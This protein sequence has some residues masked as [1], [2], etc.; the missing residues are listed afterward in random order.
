[1]SFNS[2][3]Y[4]YKRNETMLSGKHFRRKTMVTAY[5]SDVVEEEGGQE[6]G[7]TVDPDLIYFWDFSAA[8]YTEEKIT[9]DP[10]FQLTESDGTACRSQI[11][12][13]YGEI[14]VPAYTQANKY[15]SARNNNQPFPLTTF[16][17]FKLEPEITFLYEYNVSG[18]FNLFQN[19][20]KKSTML[21]IQPEMLYRFGTVASSSDPDDPLQPSGISSPINVST[22]LQTLRSANTGYPN[23][24]NFSISMF[25]PG[26]TNFYHSDFDHDTLTTQGVFQ[27]CVNG[28]GHKLAFG[29]RTD[30]TYRYFFVY[31]NK[32]YFEKSVGSSVGN[33]TNWNRHLPLIN[34]R[35]TTGDAV[36]NLK[37]IKIYK[38]FLQPDEIDNKTDRFPFL[39]HFVCDQ[40][41]TYL[42]WQSTSS[43]FDKVVGDNHVQYIQFNDDGAI[44]SYI[45][46][47]P[48]DMTSPVIWY[49]Y[50]LEVVSTWASFGIE[51]WNNYSNTPY[52]T[53][54][55]NYFDST[56]NGL[57]FGI[58]GS[59]YIKYK[60]GS[61]IV[62]TS[63]PIALSQKKYL[64]F[65]YTANDVRFYYDKTLIGTVLRTNDDSLWTSIEAQT[66]L[67]NHTRFGV[68]N[69]GLS[70]QNKVHFIVR[71]SFNEDRGLLNNDVLI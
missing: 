3:L 28:T 41:N 58:D 26:G 1:M 68:F 17:H 33:Y 52:G 46:L 14:G 51:F 66:A 39:Y 50:E 35:E 55:N 18:G 37:S 36:M 30:E 60:C 57:A 24:P 48:L 25:R 13:I 32:K 10:I 31:H 42:N 47:N 7:P 69:I 61:T 12:D 19:T 53:Y 22:G 63:T 59:Q 20:N 11:T 2:A 43:R 64:S 27:Y 21:F 5:E 56:F 34:F 71:H 16:D 29:T 6:T 62:S 54:S 4:N 23:I 70:V 38:R 44:Y 65:A 15:I 45:G 9:K 67:N 40:T 49:E 8:N